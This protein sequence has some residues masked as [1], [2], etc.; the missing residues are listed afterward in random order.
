[1][2]TRALTI[3]EDT[4]GKEI[5]C[6][7]QQYDGYPS[8]VGATLHELLKEMKIVNGYNKEKAGTH[9]NGMS[10]L[11][12]QIVVALKT[13]IGNVYLYAPGSRDCGEEYRY[14]IKPA[15]K[16]DTTPDKVFEGL[17]FGV[18]L[19]VESGCGQ[20]WETIYDGPAKGFDPE[21]EEKET[22]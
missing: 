19:K 1:M 15:G 6:I 2:G 4:D 10:C 16:T 20:K 21:M 11:A 18:L 8:G 22:A 13:D 7:Y 12:A 3:I 14:T 5:C 17:S 9:A